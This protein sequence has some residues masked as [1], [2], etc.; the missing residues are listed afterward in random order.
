MRYHE[1]KVESFPRILENI[2]GI[3]NYSL[4]L[5]LIESELLGKN[6]SETVSETNIEILKKLETLAVSNPKEDITCNYVFLMFGADNQLHVLGNQKKVKLKRISRDEYT[7]S[8]GKTY[9]DKRWSKIAY[10]KLYVF[11]ND[12][13]FEK[14][15][16][17][18]RMKFDSVIENQKQTVDITER[19]Q[20]RTQIMYHGTSSK[21]VPSILKNGLLARPPK[22]T[23]DVDTYGA[24]VASMGGVYVADEQ[25]LAEAIAEEAVG[26]HGGEPALVTIQYVKGSGDTDEDDLVSAI[27]DAA[28]TVMRTVARDRPDK[29][30]ALAKDFETDDTPTSEYDRLS[31]PDQGWAV[32]QMIKKS[33]RASDRIA[34]VT[35]E[36]LSKKGKPSKA[37]PKIVK[38]I[39]KKLLQHASQY[40]DAR[41]RWNAVSF[42]AFDIVRTQ[43]EDLLDKLM[44]QVSPDTRDSTQG[45]RRIDR[46][47]KF[48]G[49]TRILKIESPI[50]N[51]VY[52]PQG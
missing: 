28:K 24:E 10:W 17:Y 30:P 45:A 5:D 41:Q 37:A 35:T 46:D 39:A 25:D 43:Q 32:D 47:I 34:K 19:K 21:L 7:F 40:E 48:R 6:L 33:D 38:Q 29:S 42:E 49:K 2:N 1:I 23:Y 15:K 11:D 51:T 8:D 12:S 3:Q 27:T 26:T 44:R 4:Y 14:F 36:M 18:L 20:Q 31:Y 22:K 50:G 52:P 9:P 16:T 13:K